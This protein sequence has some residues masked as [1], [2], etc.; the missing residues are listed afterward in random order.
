VHASVQQSHQ[1][2]E[3]RAVTCDDVWDYLQRVSRIVISGL[4]GVGKTE[5]ASQIV[6]NARD[7]R[8][9]YKGIFWI[10]ANS[11][12]SFQ[13]GIQYMARGMKLI[14]ETEFVT[15]KGDEIR[16]MV[17]QELNCSDHW[18]LVLDNLDEA[19][20]LEDFLPERRE[21]RHVLITTRHRAMSLALKAKQIDLNPM[22]QDEAISLFTKSA[23][24][25]QAQCHHSERQLLD[26]V[27]ALG[28]LPLA[29]VQ[30]AAYL[31]ETQDDISNY[32]QFYKSSRK[33][34]WGWKPSQDSSYVT[35]ATVMA[36]S[37]G[38]VKESE[39]SI[40][41]FCLLSFLDPA[42]VS[43]T[44]WTTSDKF[45]DS[46]LR[47]TFGSSISVNSALQPLLVYN[48]V[49]RSG[50]NISMHRLVQDVMRDLIECDLQD[51]ANVLDMLNDFDRVPEYWVQRAIEIISIAYPLSHPD[52][53]A[54][55][56]MYNSHANSCITYGKKYALE[57]E[58]FGDIQRTVGKYAF[59]Q[60]GYAQARDL[61]ESALRM[62]ERICGENHTKTA[63]A[64]SDFGRSL[65]RLAKHHEAIQ[66]YERALKLKE[67]TFTKNPIDSAGIISDIG[68]SLYYLGKYDKAIQ[69]F[70][71]ALKISENT[72]ATDHIRS[73]HIIAAIG[74]VLRNQKHFK[75]AKQKCLQALKIEEAIVGR[76]H[77]SSVGIVCLLGS[78]FQC[79]GRFRK[80][81]QQYE[82]A[83][84]I[85]EKAFGRDHIG[86][87]ATVRD[88]GLSFLHLGRCQQALEQFDHQLRITEN[89]FGKDHIKTAGAIW[90]MGASY[91]FLGRRDEALVQYERALKIF[92]A[93][94]CESHKEEGIFSPIAQW[95]TMNEVYA[96][97]RSSSFSGTGQLKKMGS[98][99]RSS[100]TN[101]RVLCGRE[102]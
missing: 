23:N 8:K 89:T 65:A 66:Q 83:L 44:L 15:T 24:L 79:K 70:E 56:E 92:G 51:Q 29:L 52:T 36:I 43:E 38:K 11:A 28:R 62:Y 20:L 22:E 76:D 1:F 17:L 13:S 50:G 6:W 100:R 78:I 80:S 3:R 26:L 21:T 102:N 19:S 53:W 31:S 99:I 77:I 49:Q 10:N 7:S 86:S 98:S 48:F 68:R 40:R 4:P 91:L 25:L 84:K 59:D 14:D 75:K 85:Y 90:N 37:F 67:I 64:L 58:M 12:T 94:L 55:C 72:F 87:A 74:A 30:A 101:S 41:L 82:R 54:R 45:Q 60:G 69:Y 39:V 9:Y 93:Q 27:D 96:L 57:S 33:N 35:V 95:L 16:D 18:L 73:A 32:F 71:R 63:D 81:L 88:I 34:I 47:D 46:V 2:V 42:N 61:F 97:R 5:L